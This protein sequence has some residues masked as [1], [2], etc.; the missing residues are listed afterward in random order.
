MPFRIGFEVGTWPRAELLIVIVH[1]WV[2]IIVFPLPRLVRGA[3]R[4][5]IRCL[6]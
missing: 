2:V 4:E 1:A 6:Q 3:L 5:V